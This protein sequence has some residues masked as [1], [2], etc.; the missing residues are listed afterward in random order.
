MRIIIGITTETIQGKDLCKVEIQVEKDSHDH[1]LEQNQKV[2][3]IVIDQEQSQ[4]EGQ[5]QE[6]VHIEIGLGVYTCREY[7]HFARECPNAIT[8]E[9]SDHSDLDQVTS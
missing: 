9:D 2:E 1:G 5:A 4:D 7:G 3:Q 6:L 8:D